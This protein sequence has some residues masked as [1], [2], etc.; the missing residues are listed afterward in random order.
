MRYL[1]FLSVLF[2]LGC[3][4]SD[5]RKEIYQEDLVTASGEPAY[6]TVEH[7]L[8]SFNGVQESSSNPQQGRGRTAC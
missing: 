7:C 3:G 2:V 1:L 4:H 8:I 6:V 5:I